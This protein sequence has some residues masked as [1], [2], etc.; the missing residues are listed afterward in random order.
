MKED[1]YVQVA[2]WFRHRDERGDGS[3]LDMYGIRRTDGSRR[4][5][6]DAFRDIVAGRDTVSGACGD[7]EAPVVRIHQPTA[8]RIIGDRDS[9]VIQASSPDSDVLRMSFSI[10][11]GPDIRNFVNKPA[12]SALPA[13]LNMVAG[14]PNECRSGCRLN[15]QGVRRLSF[16]RHTVK[17]TAVD[18]SGNVGV[19]T[20]DFHRINPATLKPQPVRFDNVRF[21][22]RSRTRT[23]SG[24]VASNLPF[25]IPGKVTAEWQSRRK[26][27]KWKKVHGGARNANKT[28][29]FKQK[30]RFGGSWR[31]RVVYQGK[32]PY[33]RT[34]SCWL[35]FSTSGK[36]AK[37]VCPKGAARVLPP[38]LTPAAKK[39]RR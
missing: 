31:M 22:G 29:R 37:Q 35:Q 38:P 16:G 12:G 23:V 21:S 15:W 8:N 25:V 18:G 7:F 20:R 13:P 28:F 36:R 19:A 39:K 30:L 33:R 14:S 5:S 3:E 17:V 26:G 27:G 34:T 10:D 9:L 1:P 24:R 4:P 32:R 11:N 6:Y 2:M